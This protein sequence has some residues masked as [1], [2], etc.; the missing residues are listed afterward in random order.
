MAAHWLDALQF[1]VG[2]EQ[3]IE[4]L[5]LYAVGISAYTLVIYG[6]YQNICRRSL[7]ATDKGEW[8]ARKRLRR[9]L[10][11]LVLFPIMSFAF[12]L[13]LAISLFF[14]TKTDAAGFELAAS[15]I[16]LVS[17]AVVAGVR[18][19]AYVNEGASHDLAKILPLGLLG[20]ALVQD[21]LLTFE[22]FLPKMETLWSF[23]DT[24]ARYFLALVALEIVLRT[25]YHIAARRRGPPVAESESRGRDE[26]SRGPPTEADRRAASE[27]N[28][29][30][31]LEK[32][33]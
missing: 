9:A 5:A 21:G 27:A 11:F 19:T 31:V 25:T 2:Y 1:W 12:F 8:N 33:K 6:L 17:M 20:V 24:I 13:A 23:R 4:M 18:I 16:L 7:V 15:R 14:L 28:E 32:L 26:R 10:R 3:Q 22:S 30:A 29:R